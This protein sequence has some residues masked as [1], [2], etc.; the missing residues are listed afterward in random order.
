[1]SEEQTRAGRAAG[2]CWVM[3]GR[4]QMH[5]C[6]PPGHADDDGKGGHWTPYGGGP[7]TVRVRLARRRSSRKRTPR[8]VS[9]PPPGAGRLSDEIS[10]RHVE[11]IGNEE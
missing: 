2:Y 10:E 5:C 9:V 8:P 4:R 6:R 11:G 7:K 3:F 1:M